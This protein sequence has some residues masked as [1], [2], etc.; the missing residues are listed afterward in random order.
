[1]IFKILQFSNI[2]DF[3]VLFEYI[4]TPNSNMGN[5]NK[6]QK[7]IIKIVCISPTNL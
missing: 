4:K 3:N 6:F 2:L 1:M 5:F 7:S